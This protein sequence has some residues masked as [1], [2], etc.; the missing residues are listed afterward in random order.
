[1]NRDLLQ[2][3]DVAFGAF[4]FDSKLSAYDETTFRR[5][6]EKVFA[7]FPNLKIVASTLREIYTAS[8]HDLSAVCFFNNQTVK[9]TNYKNIDVFY[10]VGSGDAFAAGFIDGLLNNRDA[11]FAI[12][13][14][15]TLAVLTMPGDNS[16]STLAEI[17]RLLEGADSAAV[18]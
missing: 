2:F 10:R 12:E 3:V 13:S 18:R 11:Q 8:R 17:E 15:I 4:D 9:A 1:L 14:G 7:E 6:A 5:A 16:M